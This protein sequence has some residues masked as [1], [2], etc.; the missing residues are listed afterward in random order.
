MDWRWTLVRR[1]FKTLKWLGFVMIVTILPMIAL[2]MLYA[3]GNGGRQIPVAEAGPLPDF[4]VPTIGH[5]RGPVFNDSAIRTSR[6]C[7]TALTGGEEPCLPAPDE[8]RVCCSAE[9]LLVSPGHCHSVHANSRGMSMI[10]QV[11]VAGL[12]RT[13]SWV[14]VALCLL[15]LLLWKCHSVLRTQED[16][17]QEDATIS[18]DK[19]SVVLPAIPP[20]VSADILSSFLFKHV[21]S[22]H[23][24]PHAVWRVDMVRHRQDL[25]RLACERGMVADAR[26]RNDLSLYILESEA[27]FPDMDIE[28][29]EN[30]C[31]IEVCVAIQLPA[32]DEGNSLSQC[33]VCHL[34]VWFGMI[35][36]SY[37][38]WSTCR[39]ALPLCEQR[40]THR[41]AR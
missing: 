5:L 30:G 1:Y 17:E 8:V 4:F 26:D 38:G 13:A 15:W 23:G 20:W 39:D 27:G 24:R 2:V 29:Q 34:Q 12:A 16:K 22:V 31:S 33:A 19:Y 40:R 25:I 11:D 7:E 32:R 9:P 28:R 37:C 18:I 41:H 6:W 21:I 3:D 35:D 10:A 36:C 14:E